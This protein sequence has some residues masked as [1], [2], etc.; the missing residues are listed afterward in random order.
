M[1]DWL[2]PID[3][4]QIHAAALRRHEPETGKWFLDGEPFRDWRLNHS[5]SM[6]ICDN[7]GIGKTVLFSSAV[8]RIEQE[9]KSSILGSS[10]AY[11]YCS[12]RK[13]AQHD[14]SPILRTLIAQ[15]CP[16]DAIPGPLQAL[17]EKHI[18][19]F[20]PGVPSE[21]E[22]QTS[23]L[24]II[25][26]LREVASVDDKAQERDVFV[27]LDALDELTDADRGPVIKFLEWLSSHGVPKLHMLVTSRDLSGIRAGLKSWG[28]PMLMDKKGVAEDIRLFVDGAIQQDSELS[29]QRVAIKDQIK[30]RL[31]DES[32][33]L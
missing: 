9:S 24:E 27:L 15:L 18:S 8:S 10:L 33:P 26:S 17:Y 13:G 11:F 20:P 3:Q 19:K 32:N 6:W 4:S 25:H 12:Y 5:T 14:L 21:S 30:E 29:R 1:F 23:L 28:T 16:P 2:A 31:V 7:A 22:L